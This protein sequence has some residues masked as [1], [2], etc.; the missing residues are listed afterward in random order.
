MRTIR[1]R[2][3]AA[4]TRTGELDG[5]DIRSDGETFSLSDVEVL[6]PTVPSKIIGTGPNYY[7]NIEHY[8]R[9]EPESPSDL[10]LFVK[11]PPHVLVGHE[12]VATLRPHG[13]F[14]YEAE[15]GVVIGEHCREV[16]S[17][18]AMEYVEGYTC[19]NEITNKGVQ[20][21]QYDP[22]NLVRSKSFDNSAPIGPVVAS[23]D[24]VPE[25]A[26]LEL[27][28]NGEVRQ[29]DRISQLIHPVPSLIEEF[30]RY[31]TLE[32]GD[33]IATGSPEGVDKLSDGDQVEVSIE[34]IGTLK[35]SVVI[36]SP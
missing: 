32:P 17:D 34:G 21:S 20:E 13:E 18:E 6:P 30:S 12:G 8:G 3:P 26:T 36:P 7:S 9:E 31:L 28:L 29:R 24:E 14:H 19:V 33:V 35:H 11:T 23:P 5:E 15:L 25:G 16:S 22:G 2:D 4:E 27:Q 1:F 10:L